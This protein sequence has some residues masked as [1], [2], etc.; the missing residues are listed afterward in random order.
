MMAVGGGAEDVSVGRPRD[1]NPRST[2]RAGPSYASFLVFLEA[3]T[4]STWKLNM[5]CLLAH[6][7]LHALR[8]GAS[9]DL[10]E[11][12]IKQNQNEKKNVKNHCQSQSQSPK[13]NLGG[14][15][16]GLGPGPHPQFFFWLSLWLWH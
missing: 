6:I 7:L 16:G 3:W 9:A 5:D 10:R 4:L 12:Q 14:L 8:P 1:S 11:T 13:N 2:E 15:P